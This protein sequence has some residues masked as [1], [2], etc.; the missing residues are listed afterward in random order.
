MLGPRSRA[1]TLQHALEHAREH[2][3]R[4]FGVRSHHTVEILSQTPRDNA[5]L[6]AVDYLLWALQR[7]YEM[8]EERYWEF[9]RGKARLIYDVDDTRLADYGVYYTPSNPLTLAARAKK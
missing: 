8:G 1:V 5:G 6:Q 3:E 9:V 7:L 4:D 2:Y